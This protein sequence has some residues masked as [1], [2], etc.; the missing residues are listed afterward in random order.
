MPA[1][2][3]SVEVTRR[4]IESSEQS[5]L[6]DMVVELGSM[7]FLVHQVQGFEQATVV[8]AY[9]NRNDDI[10]KHV[11]CIA[12]VDVLSNANVICSPVINK[13]KQNNYDTQMLKACIAPHGNKDS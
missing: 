13:V 10:C 2:I 3:R 9:Q 5:L 12:V 6:D 1:L 8:K 11:H 7:P 4:K